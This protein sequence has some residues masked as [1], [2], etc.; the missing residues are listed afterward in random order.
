MLV[1]T[2]IFIGVGLKFASVL[3]QVMFCELPPLS[4]SPLFKLVKLT[5]GAVVSNTKST[6][7]AAA[8]I[9]PL[10]SLLQTR[11]ARLPCVPLNV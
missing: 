7:E 9:T 1:D 6:C 4:T 8:E 11:M 10:A 2:S 3:D 5:T